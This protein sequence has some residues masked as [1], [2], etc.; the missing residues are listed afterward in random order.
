MMTKC[1]FCA[2]YNPNKKKCSW[3]SFQRPIFCEEAIE[4]MT[5]AL[6][7]IKRGNE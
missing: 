7:G 3:L 4:K 1:D 5:K 6:Q 2:Y